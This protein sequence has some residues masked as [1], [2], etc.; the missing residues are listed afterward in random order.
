[1]HLEDRANPVKE[2]Y[3]SLYGFYRAFLDFSGRRL[4][5]EVVGEKV[6]SEKAL[7]FSGCNSDGKTVANN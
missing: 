2:P 3:L 4:L 5:A 1:M 6:R 7:D